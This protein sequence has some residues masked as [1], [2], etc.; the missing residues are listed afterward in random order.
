MERL[1]KQLLSYI[2]YNEQEEVDRKTML[3]AL[4]QL[5]DVFT[6]NCKLCHFTASNW[7]VNKEKNKVLMIHH[8]IY[9]SWAWTGGHAD[10]DTDLLHVA[11]KEA[12]E[13][14]GIKNFKVL[15]DGIFSLEIGNVNSHI[16]NG[17]F[18]SDHLHL[19]CTY[20]LEADENENLQ[21]QEDE[22]SDIAWFSLE[23]ATQAPSETRMKEIYLKLNNKLREI[24]KS[25]S[26]K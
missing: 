18:I 25:N 26:Y 14:T 2:P 19:N 10:G 5:S 21:I 17:E 9:N 3:Y 6:R 11:L 12:T 22:N 8:N 1:K 16:K 20:L 13:E 24:F 23:E 15:Y 4:E 7:I